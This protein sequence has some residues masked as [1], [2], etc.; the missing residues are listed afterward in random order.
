MGYTDNN[1]VIN[2]FRPAAVKVRDRVLA[3]AELV[4]IW[5]ACGDDDHGRIIK[6]LTLTGCRRNEIGDA[7]WSEID[8]N[9]ETFTIPAER[10]KN[11]REHTLPLMPMA[12][13]IIKSVPRTTRPQLFGT[14]G[15]TGFTTWHKSK[16]ALDKRLGNSVKPWRLHD[17]R[18]S[19]ATKMAD[20]GIAPHIIE[21]IL[22]HQ[23]GHKA[24]PAG[25]Y[26]RSSYERA[27]KAALALWE[28]HIRALIEGGE[29]KVVNFQPQTAS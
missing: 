1:P 6:L 19:V 22:N 21:Q 29:R 15:P 28:D 3:D 16:R 12:L 11:K 18:R 17:V 13:G 9:R 4:A 2:S 20:I 24:G 27:V 23:S 7:C 5:N 14:R 25:I 26:N 8:F 10:S